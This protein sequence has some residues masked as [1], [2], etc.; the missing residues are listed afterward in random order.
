MTLTELY[1]TANDAAKA[2]RDAGL[3]EWEVTAA[4][5][6]VFDDY[7]TEHGIG[8]RNQWQPS[9]CHGVPDEPESEQQN[10]CRTERKGDR[11]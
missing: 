6:K 4:R 9:L 3:Q 1:E 8:Y 5:Q 7:R 2:A 11:F 10:F